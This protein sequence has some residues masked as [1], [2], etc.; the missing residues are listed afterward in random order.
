[1]ANQGG[2]TRTGGSRKNNCFAL[3]VLHLRSNLGT[4]VL[5]DGGKKLFGSYEA[6]KLI[7]YCFSKRA[8][9]LVTVNDIRPIDNVLMKK[10]SVLRGGLAVEHQRQ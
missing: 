7:T 1:M 2:F 3:R 10:F 4:N 9:V 6:P 8:L 5:T